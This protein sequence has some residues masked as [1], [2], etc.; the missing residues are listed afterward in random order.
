MPTST[1]DYADETALDPLLWEKR[2]DDLDELDALD[3]DPWW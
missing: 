3:A 1:T 2:S